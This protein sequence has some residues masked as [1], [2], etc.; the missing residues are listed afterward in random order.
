MTCKSLDTLEDGETFTNKTKTV[1]TY[2]NL[3]AEANSK[4]TTIVHKPV[5]KHEEILPRTGK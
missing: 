1:G 5:E 3:K 2:F 4:W